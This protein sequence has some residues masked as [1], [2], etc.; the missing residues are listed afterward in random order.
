MFFSFL[1]SDTATNTSSCATPKRSRIT[2]YYLK[3]AAEEVQRAIKK[4]DYYV[5]DAAEEV[6]RAIKKKSVTGKLSK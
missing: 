2:D 4:S 5:K 6:Q 3:D 1:F